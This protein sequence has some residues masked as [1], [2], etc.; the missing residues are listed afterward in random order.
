MNRLLSGERTRRAILALMFCIYDSN[1]S[2]TKTN[3]LPIT[4]RCAY[5]VISR[6]SQMNL[7]DPG[8]TLPYHVYI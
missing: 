3:V 1:D 6:S 4:K 5:T 7:A 2:K 8:A